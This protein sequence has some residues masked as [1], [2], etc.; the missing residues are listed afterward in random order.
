[1]RDE[2][3]YRKTFLDCTYS[4]RYEETRGPIRWQNPVQCSCSV[5]HFYR[6]C[7]KNTLYISDCN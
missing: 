7:R 3:T 4:N 1:M 2:I 6:L 5:F